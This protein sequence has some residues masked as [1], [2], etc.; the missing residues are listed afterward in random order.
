MRWV[1]CLRYAT[2]FAQGAIAAYFVGIGA[3]LWKSAIFVA[4]AAFSAW[5]YITLD[6]Q[7]GRL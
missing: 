4:L 1:H 3:G 2:V 7:E 6:A 5:G